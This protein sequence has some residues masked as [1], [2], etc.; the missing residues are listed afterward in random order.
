MDN[1]ICKD[2]P[3]SS[4]QLVELYLNSVLKKKK[5]LNFEIYE[6]WDKIVQNKLKDHLKIKEV[7]DDVLILVADHPAWVQKANMSKK[8]ILSKIKK[9]IPITNIKS[10]HIICR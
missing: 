10:I 2:N 1:R 7:K 6:K 3:I 5:P 8:N 9:E 4:K